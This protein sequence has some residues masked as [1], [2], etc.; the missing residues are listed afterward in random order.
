VAPK[1]KPPK[2]PKPKPP[3]PRPPDSSQQ[4]ENGKPIKP[5]AKPDGISEAVA[6]IIWRMRALKTQAEIH[7]AFA[8]AIAALIR[9]GRLDGIA[10]LVVEVGRETNRYG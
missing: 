8:K 1:P 6:S 7:R 5:A 10:G 9:E 4:P 2:P 3:K